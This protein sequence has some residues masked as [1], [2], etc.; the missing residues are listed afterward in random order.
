MVRGFNVAHAKKCVP[1]T[2]C[3]SSI[4]QDAGSMRVYHGKGRVGRF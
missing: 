1:E 2:S 3:S 4:L